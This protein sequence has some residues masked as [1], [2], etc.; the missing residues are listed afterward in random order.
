MAHLHVYLLAMRLYLTSSD[1]QYAGFWRYSPHD[2]VAPYM[3]LLRGACCSVFVGPLV[4]WVSIGPWCPWV[5][6]PL[7][8]LAP[9]LVLGPGPPASWPWVVP[10]TCWR[11]FGGFLKTTYLR[12]DAGPQGVRSTCCGPLYRGL[13]TSSRNA[14]CKKQTVKHN[15]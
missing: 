4:P 5:S 12:R 7:W 3:V 10:F 15:R 14:N 11:C 8:S 9:G 13:E 1:R 2:Q 6:A